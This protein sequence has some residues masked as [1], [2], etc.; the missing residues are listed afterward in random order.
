MTRSR[1]RENSGAEVQ[2]GHSM[3]KSAHRDATHRLSHDYLRRLPPEYYRGQA[4]VHWSMTIDDRK[5]GWLIPIFYYKFREILTHTMFRYGLCCPIYCCMPDHIH[6]LWVGLFNQTDQ[7]LASRFFRKQ[8][9]PVLDKVGAPL[10]QQPYD[11]VL[12]EEER[13]EKE[14]QNVAEYIARNPE[15]AGLVAQDRY[16]DYPYTGCLV[17]G[18]PDLKPWQ[19]GYWELFWRLYFGLAKRGFMHPQS[20][21]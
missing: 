12:Q 7:R 15:R 11:H 9:N 19:H 2:G 14:F 18:Y 16:R 1:I 17:P 6:L 20:S 13:R 5:R 3:S 21:Q 4:Y 10:Q 8:I